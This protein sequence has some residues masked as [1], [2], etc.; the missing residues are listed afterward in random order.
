VGAQ[1]DQNL[2]SWRYIYL[3]T[4]FGEDQCMQF[5]VIVVTDTHTNKQ[6]HR[7]DRLQYTALLSLARSVMIHVNVAVSTRHGSITLRKFQFNYN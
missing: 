1:D 2:I 7:Q 6:T 5:Q 4:Q 3:Q